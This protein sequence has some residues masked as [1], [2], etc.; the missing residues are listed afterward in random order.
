MTLE[1]DVVTTLVLAIIVLMI[2]RALISRIGFLSRYNIPEPVVG[3]LL[4]ACVITALHIWAG[5]QITFD[6]SL[7]TPLML[8]FFATIGLSADLR[9]LVQGGRAVVIFLL[10]VV[11]MLLL[12]NAVGV[13]VAMSMDL[14]PLAGLLAGSITMSGGHGT[15]AAYATRFSEVDGVQGAMEIAMACATFGLVLGGLLGGPLA[16]KLITRHRLAP[17]ADTHETGAP[18]E[19]ESGMRRALSPESFLE[20]LLLILAC[21]MIGSWL[22]KAFTNP[23]LTLPTFVWTL[24]TGVLLRNVLSLGRL[25]H[26][27]DD[28]V[29]LLGTV[30]LSLFLA[31]AL[32]ALRLWEL[33]ALAL[34]ILAI[35]AAQVVAIAI[36]VYFVTFR[37][38][39]KNYDAAVMSAGHVGFGMGATPTAI[40]N[41]QALTA[42]YGPSRQAFLIIP[43]VGAFLIDLANA[44]VIQ[45]FMSLPMFGF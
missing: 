29:E 5:A 1:I 27:D 36:Y 23:Y 17:A 43:V 6:M 35:L 16:Q 19:L 22:G 31:M 42:R 30:S 38:M 12:Q 45:G 32:I 15:G 20:T 4:A 9:S 3:G 8:A 41:M 10:V 21:I 13:A 37:V 2:G 26:I 25:R 18:G 34:P 39:G 14:H 33:V 44:L 28:T 24:F 7:Q 11:V 40:A